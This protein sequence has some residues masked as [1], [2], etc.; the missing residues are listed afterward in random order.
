MGTHPTSLTQSTPPQTGTAP[1]PPTAT[2]DEIAGEFRHFCEHLFAEKPSTNAEPLLEELRKRTVPTSIRD[3]LETPITLEEIEL[4]IHKLTA[5]KTPG[6]DGLGT[7]YYKE[8]SDTL[9]PHLLALFTESTAAGHLPSI[10]T[11]G[12][13]SFLFK[14]GDPR[15]VRNYRP[16]SLLQVDYKILAHIL[17]RRIKRTLDY[18]ISTE[19]L[20]F[21]PG[22]HIS[23]ATHLINL[24]QA[25]LEDTN[26][27]G[28]IL[29]LDWEKAFDR[30]SWDYYHKALKALGFR[31]HFITYATLL[32]NPAHPPRRRVKI[33]GRHSDYFHL[34]C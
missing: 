27:E 2:D 29:T 14:K 30:C 26:E 25:Y 8:F 5:H 1:Q 6:P 12:D 33:N 21:V 34:R 11:E 3:E 13:L 28:I 31:P 20:G 24:I 19:Q 32:S 16:I 10:L 9:A 23:E 18:V 7:E 22:R 15:E 17:V 4:A